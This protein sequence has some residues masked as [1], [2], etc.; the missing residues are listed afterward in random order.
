LRKELS[1]LQRVERFIAGL[2]N[3]VL[4]EVIHSP[5]RTARANQPALS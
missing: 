1:L 5:D 3:R 4:R 2:V